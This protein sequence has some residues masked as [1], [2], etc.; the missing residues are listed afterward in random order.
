MTALEILDSIYFMDDEVRLTTTEGKQATTIDAVFSQTYE[1]LASG[2]YNSTQI[3]SIINDLIIA[4]DRGISNL[5]GLEMG[6]RREGY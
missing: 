5:E 1:V 4:F 6:L 2:D 3:R